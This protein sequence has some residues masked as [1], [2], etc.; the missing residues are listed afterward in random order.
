M[1]PSEI[2]KFYPNK[3]GCFGVSISSEMMS[4]KIILGRFAA[5]FPNSSTL[6][7]VPNIF[8]FK[9]NVDL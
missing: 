3:L 9:N 6:L 4:S 2:V 8:A 1:P 7:I 5:I